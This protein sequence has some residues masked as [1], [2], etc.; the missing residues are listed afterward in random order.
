M[1]KQILLILFI[2]ISN[3]STAQNEGII[4]HYNT[5]ISLSNYYYN[6]LETNAKNYQSTDV[7]LISYKKYNSGVVSRLHARYAS[8]EREIKLLEVA[9]L[10]SPSGLENKESIVSHLK[11][12]ISSMNKNR[13]LDEMLATYVADETYKTDDDLKQFHAYIERFDKNAVSVISNCTEALSLASDQTFR[14][15]L[16]YLKDAPFGAW[17]VPMKKDL[18]EVDLIFEYLA[19]LN[20]M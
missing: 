6:D 9:V 10:E 5:I 8:N 12:A 19:H 3:L 16:E 13:A 2:V 4:E 7:N 15:E 11:A 18:R 17:I 14:I 20:L 1:N